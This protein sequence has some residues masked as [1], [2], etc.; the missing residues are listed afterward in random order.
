MKT[1]LNTDKE[2]LLKEMDRFSSKYEQ[3]KFNSLSGTLAGGSVDNLAI[4]LTEFN[5]INEEWAIAK[6][7]IN[8][9]KYLPFNQRIYLI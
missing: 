2:N 3:I 6:N 8:K 5:Q 1:K 7:K 9:L 4:H